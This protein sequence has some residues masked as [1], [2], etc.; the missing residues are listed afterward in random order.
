MKVHHSVGENVFKFGGGTRLKS[1]G[2]YSLP[3]V[4][5]GKEVILRTDIVESHIPLLLSRTAMKKAAIKMDLE[6]D[7]A[8]IIGKDVSL[9]LTTSGHYCTPIDKAEE[10]PV[11]AV[12]A[13]RLDNLSKQDQYK[14]ILK[15][16]RQ[17]AH[18]TKKD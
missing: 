9:N 5:A 11:E 3:A 8:S 7:T 6:N 15:L 14:T 17:F 16:H 10:V 18:Q 4:I 1:M 12:C 13:V 2:E